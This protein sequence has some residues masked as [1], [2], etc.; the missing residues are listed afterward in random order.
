MESKKAN[1][2]EVQNRILVTTGWE[3]CGEEDGERLR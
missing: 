2:I 1:L 3:R